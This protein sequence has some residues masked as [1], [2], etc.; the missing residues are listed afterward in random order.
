[1]KLT[2]NCALLSLLA[3]TMPSQCSPEQVDSFCDLYTKIIV[4]K[5]DSAIQAPLEVKK[6]LLTNEKL[7]L[8]VCT[9]PKQT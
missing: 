5:G 6:R 4:N 8:K 2:R 3:L 9:Q 7:Y 1:M